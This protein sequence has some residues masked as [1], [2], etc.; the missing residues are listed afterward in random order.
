MNVTFVC[1]GGRA[2]IPKACTDPKLGPK[3]APKCRQRQFDDN[4][5]EDPVN[6]AETQ[7]IEK[8]E[9]NR[10]CRNYLRKLAA[11]QRK[12]NEK[13]QKWFQTECES[14]F[15]VEKKENKIEN[16]K[17]NFCNKCWKEKKNE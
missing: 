9:F 5:N 6:E 8:T 14:L 17:V 15:D 4:E 16:E 3:I 13:A 10:V 7:D 2:G 11:K 12:E 1:V